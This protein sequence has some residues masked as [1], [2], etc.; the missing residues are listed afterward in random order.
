VSDEAITN[1]RTPWHQSLIVRVVLL[2]AIL[3]FCLL[4]SVLVI[5]RH[6]F[7]EVVN[8]MESQ[9]QTIGD[10][11]VLQLK[12]NPD[13]DIE[14]LEN[15]LKTIHSGFDEI[16]LTPHVDPELVSSFSIERGDEGR[17]HKVA[18]VPLALD[19]R[20][21]LLTIHISSVMQTEI[22]RAFKN[23]YLAALIALFLG[24]VIL[25][26]YFIVKMLRPIT[27]LSESCAQIGSGNLKDVVVRRNTGEILALE[28]TFNR[29]VRSLREKEVMESKLRQAERVSA[30]GNLAAGVAHDVRNPLNTIKLLASHVTDT[31]DG[32][33]GTEAAAKQLQIVRGEIGRI[34]DIVSGF[35]SLAT[36]RE[37][38]LEPYR[39][40]T[41]LNECLRLVRKDAELRAIDIGAELRAGDTALMLDPKQWTRAILNVLIN[42]MDACGKGGR[43]RLFSRVTDATC[44]IE[45]RDNGRGLS[46]EVADRAFDPYFTTK[47]TG[48]GLGLSMARRV[49]EDH[50]GTITL[51]GAEGVG[52]QVLITVP[53]TRNA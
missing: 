26:V 42:A 43:V 14:D 20:R 5:T 47:D 17:L 10:D 11:V 31:L 48:T 45:I 18:R 13:I 34:E 24:A 41:L 32:T 8:E 29:M 1:S 37:L 36:E 21:I 30:L 7:T 12:E 4:G 2:C 52:C 22:L 35:L 50:H 9:A 25:M 39:V 53:L 38:H 33:P 46:K 51:S 3:V 6:F 16:Q 23:K 49:I 40:D 44:E 19:D 28:Q 15:G 27:D